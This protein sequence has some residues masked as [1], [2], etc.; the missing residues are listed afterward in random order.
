MVLVA[1]VDVNAVVEKVMPPP[2]VVTTGVNPSADA[3]PVMVMMLPSGQVPALKAQ[4]LAPK[5]VWS[6]ALIWFATSRATLCALVL[7]CE[8][9]FMSSMPFTLML[10]TDVLVFPETVIFA[11]YLVTD[12]NL[13]A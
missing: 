3:G 12:P 10:V 4:T 1:V 7:T 11:V 13:C 6:G 8:T 5:S 2:S 9:S